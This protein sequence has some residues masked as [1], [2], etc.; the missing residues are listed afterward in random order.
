MVV[1]SSSIGW[2]PGSVTCSDGTSL[3]V[4]TTFV[5]VKLSSTTR[6]AGTKRALLGGGAPRGAK[7]VFFL[8]FVAVPLFWF[9]VSRLAIHRPLFCGEGWHG[10]RSLLVSCMLRTKKS[11]PIR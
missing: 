6:T 3:L 4:S 11:T 2:A 8:G 1:A 9:F 10:L 5:S 7:A